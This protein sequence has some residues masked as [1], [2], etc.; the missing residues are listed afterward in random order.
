MSTLRPAL[1]VLVFLSLGGAGCAAAQ[2]AAPPVQS[3]DARAEADSLRL[4]L[5]ERAERE[6]ET[7]AFEALVEDS[8]CPE[9]V[10]CIWAGRVQVR[11]T[12]GGEPVVLTLPAREEGEQEAVERGG[13]RVALVGL[14]G[15]AEAP[16]VVLVTG[17]ADG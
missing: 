17:P 16:E 2:E 15:G 14:E 9:G 7:V 12:V 3:Q 11:L 8:R 1:A 6:G 13:V 10:Q 4:A 5:G